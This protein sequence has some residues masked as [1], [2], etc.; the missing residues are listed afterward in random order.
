M[1]EVEVPKEVQKI[2]EV[3]ILG[4]GL[5]YSGKGDRN[6]YKLYICGKGIEK[7]IRWWSFYAPTTTWWCMVA[8]NVQN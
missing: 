6:P 8:K 4:F 3:L 5:V 1:V 2:V 7:G